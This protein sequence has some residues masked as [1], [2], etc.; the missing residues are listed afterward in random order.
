MKKVYILSAQR[1]PIGSFGGSLSSLSAVQLGCFAGKAAIARAGIEAS[2]INEVFFGNVCAANL[3]QAPA[4]QIALGSGI[5]HHVPSTTINK[6]CASGMKSAMIGAMSLQYADLP[7][8]VG[9]TESMSNIPHY[10]ADLRWGKKYGHSSVL[11]GLQRDGLTD[12]YDQVAMG[13]FADETAVEFG[14]SREEQDAYAIESYKRSQAATNNGLFM[15]EICSISI[16]Q[17]KG[18]DLIIDKD[19]ECFNVV[20]D[21]IPSLRAAFSPNGTVTAANASTINDGSAA[22]ILANEDYVLA[23]GLKPLAE[24]ISFSDAAH[25]PQRFTTAP[26]LA[27]PKALTRANLQM[28][29]IDL[30]EVNEAFSVVSLAF[31]KSFNLSHDIVNINGGAVALGHPLGASGARIMT[32]LVHAMRNQQKELGLATICNGGGG[33]SAIVLKLV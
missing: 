10:L 27:A 24:I 28:T 12:V 6:V 32:T 8:M 30:F 16:P 7:V 31:M 21:K 33:A 1:S 4:R 29:D 19:E 25:N 15:N 5:G 22:L 14:I 9:G 2:E 17:K 11:D 20:F 26:A 3:G 18:N 23:H 13:S